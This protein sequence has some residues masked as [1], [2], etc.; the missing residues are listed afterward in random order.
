M[1][2]YYSLEINANYFFYRIVRNKAADRIGRNSP[3]QIEGGDRG[4]PQP[5]QQQQQ[6]QQ[7]LG[8]NHMQAQTLVSVN[9]SQYPIGTIISIPGAPAQNDPINATTHIDINNSAQIV[10]EVADLSMGRKRESCKFY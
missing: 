9:A 2:K 3:T 7:Q 4:T 1:T 6:Q 8:E 5:Q 10:A